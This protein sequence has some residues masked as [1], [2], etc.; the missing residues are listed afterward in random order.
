MKH[1]MRK[2]RA[3]KMQLNMYFTYYKN[4]RRNSHYTHNDHYNRLLQGCIYRCYTAI[5]HE[6]SPLLRSTWFFFSQIDYYQCHCSMNETMGRSA[7]D[8]RVLLNDLNAYVV[9]TSLHQLIHQNPHFSRHSLSCQLLTI[10]LLF[11]S[12]VRK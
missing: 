3:A 2:S 1:K 12:F 4:V 6:D 11:S 8:I 7:S 10:R 9:A 5:H